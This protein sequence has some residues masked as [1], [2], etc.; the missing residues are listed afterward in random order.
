MLTSGF[1]F[2][3]LGSLHCVGM[4]GPIAFSLP[5][6]GIKNPI[7]KIYLISLYH[8][9]RIFS[10]A[11]I[12]LFFGL[13][14]KG[15]SLFGIQQV[16]SII[17]GALMILSVVSYYTS[18]FKI[19]LYKPIYNFMLKLKMY[20]GAQFKNKNPDT[21]LTIGFLNGFLPCGLIYIAVLG[22]LSFGNVF[23]SMLYMILFGLGTVPLMT[24]TSYLKSFISLNTRLWLQKLVPILIIALGILFVIRG[25]GLDIPYLSPASVDL[26][27][28]KVSSGYECSVLK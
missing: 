6:G 2:G 18:S 20:L 7:K 5:T 4:C 15:L 9:G 12:G 13:I 25:L 28:P 1:I 8:L 23:H 11:L 22:S 10:Y 24:A 19:G 16:L 21:F 3:F 14:G 17:I 27:S 26:A